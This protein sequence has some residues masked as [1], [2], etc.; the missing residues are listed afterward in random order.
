MNGHTAI[1]IGSGLLQI[2]VGLL[3]VSVTIL[4]LITPVWLSAF[5]SLAGSV[6][7]MTGVVL[8]YH[9]VTSQ[10]TFESLVNQSIRRTISAQN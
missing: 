4:G 3:L 9:T 8:V 10:G 5:L 6:S 1:P 2:G 7:C